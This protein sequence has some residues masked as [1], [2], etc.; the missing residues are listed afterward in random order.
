MEAGPCEEEEHTAQWT[1]VE[2][3]PEASGEVE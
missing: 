3:V 1:V 2:A